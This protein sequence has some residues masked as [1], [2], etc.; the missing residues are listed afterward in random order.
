MSDLDRRVEV[1]V[2]HVEALL[3]NQHRSFRLVHRLGNEEAV[4]SQ[5]LASLL[6]S[7]EVGFRGNL[8]P[9]DLWIVSREGGTLR[10]DSRLLASQRR[11]R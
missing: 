7:R 6:S 1:Q 9:V 4:S 10:K 3:L 11:L 2:E 8:F 5:L